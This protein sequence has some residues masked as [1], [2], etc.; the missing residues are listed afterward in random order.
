MI[1]LGSIKVI[2]SKC[3]LKFDKKGT[4][5]LK[6]KGLQKEDLLDKEKETIERVGE[7]HKYY[8]GGT[9]YFS[10]INIYGDVGELEKLQ[11]ALQ[12]ETNKAL[13]KEQKTKK[14]YPKVKKT[15]LGE[16]TFLR[17][18]AMNG[19]LSSCV[20]SFN[21]Q[22]NKRRKYAKKSKEK[23]LMKE[24]TRDERVERVK[25]TQKVIRKRKQNIND[26]TYETPINL[27]FVEQFE[28]VEPKFDNLE[29]SELENALLEELKK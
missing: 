20:Y 9:N 5:F 26:L 2:I 19:I 8:I 12:V 16:D 10:S 3:T 13:I 28:K 18:F 1:Q 17:N 23:T 29:G 21:Y 7:E 25:K 11:N 6:C 14:K 22:Y 24:E 15:L 4:P 27:D